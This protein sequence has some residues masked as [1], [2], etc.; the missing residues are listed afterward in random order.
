MLRSGADA[1]FSPEIFLPDSAGNVP[2]ELTMISAFTTPTIA[3]D[4]ESPSRVARIQGIQG[5]TL[6][7]DATKCS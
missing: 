1:A 3:S 6:A 2:A 4:A 5:Q 7:E